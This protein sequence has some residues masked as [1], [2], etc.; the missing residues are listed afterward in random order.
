MRRG[1]KINGGVLAAAIALAC[2]EPVWVHLSADRSGIV[3]ETEVGP[4]CPTGPCP[5]GHRPISAIVTRDGWPGIAAVIH[6]SPNGRFHMD[7]GPGDY[8]IHIL[9]SPWHA[10]LPRLQANNLPAHVVPHAFVQVV[11]AFDSGIR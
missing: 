5:P 4:T 8:T 3:G 10:P 6:T 11:V 2:V 1:L 7:L 9:Q